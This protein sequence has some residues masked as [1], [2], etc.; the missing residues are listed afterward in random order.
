MKEFFTSESV[1]EGHPDKLCDLIADNLLDEYLKGDINSRVGIEVCCGKGMVFVTGEVTSKSVVNVEKVVRKTI[2]NMGYFGKDYDID[3]KSCKVIINLS[4]QSLDIARGVNDLVGG[5]GDQGI[6]FGYATDETKTYMPIAIYYAHLLTKRLAK[7]RKLGIITGIGCDG[8]SEVTF[9]YVDGVPKRIENIVISIQ[10]RE[11]KDLKELKE[12]INSKVI[13]YV[14]PSNLIDSDTKIYIN[15]TG[16]FVIG[17]P[18]GDSGVTG[19]KIVVDTYGG[20]ARVGGGAFSGKDPTKVDR[21]ACYMARFIAKNLVYNGYCRK[22]EVGL[23]YAI[24]I[25]QPLS[26]YLNTFGT[27]TI[28]EDEILSKITDNFDLSPKGIID[29]LDLK[30]LKYSK[31]TNYGHFGKNNLSYEKLIHF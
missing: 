25:K 29:Y 18:L 2:K 26:I 23:S 7:V 9:E 30:H 14:I 31:T 21:S 22:C 20:Y 11:D 8:K 27:N 12:E 19:R 1:C 24:G 5:A 15:P 28:S 10:H 4:E 16:R 13:S 3:Y 17:G 6:M